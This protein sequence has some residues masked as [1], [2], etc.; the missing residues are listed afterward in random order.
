M[1]DRAVIKAVVQ[2]A[3]DA[4]FVA[5]ASTGTEDRHGEIV[6]VDGWDLKAFKA[7][8]VL[9]WAHDHNEPAVGVATKTWVDKTGKNPALMIKGKFHEYTDKARAIKQMV[10]D[11]IIKTM[12]VGF[13]PTE[14]DGNTYTKQELLE[15]SFVNVPANSQAQISAIKSLREA[16]FQDEVIEG[17]G[18]PVS[19]IDRL[20][21]LEKSVESL[22]KTVVKAPTKS[23]VNP[24]GRASDVLKERQRNVKIILRASDKLLSG[25]KSATLPRQ[26][27]VRLIKI[28]K[29]AG[30][31]IASSQKEQLNGKN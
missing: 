19:L 30:E 8:P 26:E 23:T 29:R 31:K 4:D 9:L 16:G 15:V 27:Q 17:V 20:D 7:N 5:V 1:K 13:R 10:E 6:S 18:L 2:K 3:S 24:R 28:V 21:T 25:K 12:S 11:G 22:T 14:M